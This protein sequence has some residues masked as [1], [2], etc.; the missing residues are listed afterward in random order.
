MLHFTFDYKNLSGQNI[1]AKIDYKVDNTV[2][3][4]NAN[5]SV[6]FDLG[7]LKSGRHTLE[8]ICGEDTLHC[9]FTVFSL[10]D[11]KPA[12][13][14]EDWFYASSDHFREDGKP[15]YVQIGSS[16]HDVMV[17]Y[18]MLSGSKVLESGTFTLNDELRTRALKYK[19]EYHD[20]ITLAYAWVKDGV[21]HSHDITVRRPEPKLEL[22]TKWITFRDKLMPGQQETWTL[23]ITDKMGKPARAQLM[24][25]MYDMSLDDIYAHNWDL[26]VRF[27][28]Y[29]P[30][31]QWRGNSFAAMS[32]YGEMPLKQLY[33][34]SFDFT[35][36]VL[37]GY[38][39]PTVYVRGSRAVQKSS[40]TGSMVLAKEEV[41]NALCGSLSAVLNEV[42]TTGYSVPKKHR[43]TQQSVQKQTSLRKNFN[44]TA[45][46]FPA[47]QTDNKGNVSLKFTLPESVTTWRLLGLA[48]D[49][50]MNNAELEATAVA[51]KSVMIMPNMP[52]FVRMGDQAML[53]NRVV[54][55]TGKV[56]SGQVEMLILDPKT[57]KQL[58]SEAKKL[59]LAPNATASVAF[60]FEPLQLRTMGCDLDAVVCRMVVNGQSFSDGEQHLLPILS[61]KE[62]V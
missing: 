62:H 7:K 21:L 52:R 35:H 13:E 6:T 61:D 55:T 29:L 39:R 51:K 53:S 49:K 4:A 42:V 27:N 47:L 17:Y 34:R 2:Y 41:A 22:H 8:A 19:E 28:W 30:Y 18:S 26:D 46:F 5:E 32:L 37:N 60:T 43:E 44:E 14:A 10:K 12:D 58:F 31:M 9:S 3:Q 50:E 11:K 38:I 24:A 59:T 36:Y 16:R 1:A 25:T 33:V 15:V 57:G 20:G 40:M 45:F 56:Q 23:Q 48:H 54:N